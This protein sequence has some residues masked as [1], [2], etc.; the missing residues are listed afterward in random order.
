MAR[1]SVAIRHEHTRGGQN[2]N[3]SV[4]HKQN[5]RHPTKRLTTQRNEK[6]ERC[7][8]AAKYLGGRQ[9]RSQ[10]RLAEDLKERRRLAACVLAS[11]R[12]A[13]A[14]AAVGWGLGTD[15]MVLGFKEVR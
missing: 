10:S 1:K 15:G 14:A 9:Q 11:D 8:R 7:V 12:S 3:L 4:L 13:A 5:T 6:E 2:N